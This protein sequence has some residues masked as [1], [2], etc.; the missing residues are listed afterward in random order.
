MYMFLF[1]TGK[2]SGNDM[3][4]LKTTGAPKLDI[5]NGGKNSILSSAGTSS[6]KGMVVEFSRKLDTKDKTDQPIMVGKVNK[7]LL[8]IGEDPSLTKAHKK[9]GRWETEITFK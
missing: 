8:A 6:D 2:L 1:D 5:D 4:M 3:V 7:V 9:G